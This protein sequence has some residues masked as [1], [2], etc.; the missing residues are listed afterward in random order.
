MR[1]LRTLKFYGFCKFLQSFAPSSKQCHYFIKSLILP[2]LLYN[3]ELWFYSCTAG[4]RHLLLRPFT[5]A[6]F[7]SDIE[8]IIHQRVG[9]T[10]ENFYNDQDHILNLCYTKG[11]RSTTTRYRDSFVPTSIGFLNKPSAT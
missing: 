11:S 9:H 6:N 4:D 1:F 7:N 8:D 3:S 5:R 10:T 2:I